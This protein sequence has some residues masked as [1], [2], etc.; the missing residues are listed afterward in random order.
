MKFKFPALLLAMLLAAGVVQAA[1]PAKGEKG[2]SEQGPASVPGVSEDEMKKLG[3]ARKAAQ[4]VP[5][6][7]DAKAAAEAAREKAKAAEGDAKEAAVKAAMEAG[8]AFHDAEK[9]A[10]LKADPSLEAV[11][12]KVEEAMKAK[13]EGKEKGKKK[14]AK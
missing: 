8:K 10:I 6:V 5:A 13:G 2:K 14:K 9:A 3:D 4:E 1:K 11:L 12:A 7:K